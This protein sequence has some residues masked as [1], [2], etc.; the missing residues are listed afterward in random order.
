ML[1]RKLEVVK[2]TPHCNRFFLLPDILH[3]IG[4]GGKGGGGFA[5]FF[6]LMLLNL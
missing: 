1:S 6:E 3:T 5:N 2:G 4:F